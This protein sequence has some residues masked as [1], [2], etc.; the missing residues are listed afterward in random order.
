METLKMADNTHMLLRSNL[1]QLKLPTMGA[2][3]DKLAREAA[4]ANEGYEQY[5]LRLTELEVSARASNAVQARIR[6]AGFPV[7]KDLDTFDFTALPHLSKPK[8]LELARGEW[9]EQRSN[10]CLIGSPGTGK[11][12]LATALGLSACR[13]GKRV[14]FFTAAALVTRLE[15]AQK[16]YQLDRL[17]GQLDKTDLLICDELGYLSFSRAGAELLFQVFA[18]RYERRSLLVTS[19]LAFGEWGQVFQGERMTAALLDR[20][21]HRCHILEMNSESFRFRESMKSKKGK[22]AEGGG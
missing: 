4:A 19:N 13:Q 17:L 18:D 7:A 22:K 1:K 11:T 14:R 12:H 3:F 8:V 2:E 10:V 20:L 9:I 15:E 5:L 21:T 6:A 16:Q